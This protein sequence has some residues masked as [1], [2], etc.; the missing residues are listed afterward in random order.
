MLAQG[1][2][3]VVN[4]SSTLGG[5][6]RQQERPS[7]WEVSMLWRDDEGCGA[8]RRFVWRSC[9]CGG[10]WADRDGYVEAVCGE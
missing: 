7:M 2:G 9:E 5:R 6:G 3:S 8:G 10:A 4:V 1:K